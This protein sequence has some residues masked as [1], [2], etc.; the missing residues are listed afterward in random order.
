M[1]NKY[2]NL[3]KHNLLSVET[4]AAIATIESTGKIYSEVMRW[5][6]NQLA[7]GETSTKLIV[8]MV[9]REVQKERINTKNITTDHINAY[10]QYR[11]Y[12]FLT[13]ELPT[14]IDEEK[15]RINV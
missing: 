4:N 10:L 1:S 5:M 2:L 12:I 7:N 3:I 9:K 14:M 13:E 6:Y 11:Y 15:R 8:A